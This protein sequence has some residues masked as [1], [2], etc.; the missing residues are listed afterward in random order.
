MRHAIRWGLRWSPMLLIL[1]CAPSAY[2]QTGGTA[3][4]VKDPQHILE[5]ADRFEERPKFERAFTCGTELVFERH[6]CALFSEPFLRREICDESVE[7][8]THVVVGE[9]GPESVSFLSGG[10]TWIRV[11]REDYARMG[12]LR[13]MLRAPKTGTFEG[14]G[15]PTGRSYVTIDSSEEEDFRLSNGQVL[16]ALRVRFTYYM[17]DEEQKRHF[18]SVHSLV[19]GKA[20]ETQGMFLEH[21]IHGL[22][23][24]V[25]KVVRIEPPKK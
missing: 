7:Q 22:R 15:E 2:G 11:S 1:S 21:R 3:A 16:K 9:C 6:R 4:H 10:K 5:V 13:A 18:P 25:S 12:F 17:Y 23:N 14:Q 19:I 20:R 24:P 8:E